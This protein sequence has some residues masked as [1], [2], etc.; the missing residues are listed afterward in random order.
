MKKICIHKLLLFL[1]IL[2]CKEKNISP[3]KRNHTKAII[4]FQP[5]EFTDTAALRFLKTSVENFYP[6]SVTVCLNKQLSKHLYYPPRN[7]YRADS[8]IH[9]L[10]KGVTDSVQTIVGIT[11][12]DISVTKEKIHD[13]GVM[14][15]GYQPGKACVVSTFRAAKTAKNKQHLQERLLKLVLHEM[16]HNFGLPHCVNKQC[17]MVDAEGQMKL[18][19]EV[20]LCNS[21]QKKLNL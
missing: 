10:Q 1:L 15:L 12:Q 19:E 2:S 16:G 5:L 3:A 18:D 6:V 9:W 21:C 14:G 17:F 13:Y 7:R 4:F 20:D 8:I 11:S